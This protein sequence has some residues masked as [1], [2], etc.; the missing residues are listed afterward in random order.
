MRQAAGD[1]ETMA[2]PDSQ[3]KTGVSD[4]L[5]ALLGYSQGVVAQ[6]VDVYGRVPRGGRGGAGVSEY[7]RQ[8]LKAA[9]LAK[10][11]STFKLL[12]DWDDDGETGVDAG[13][14]ASSS[15]SVRKRFRRKG[16]SE[17]DEAAIAHDSGRNVRRRRS[18]E[19]EKD[20][21]GCG[22]SGEEEEMDR[23][24]IEKAQLERNIRERD[25][26]N[27]RRPMDRKATKRE[28]DELARRSEAMAKDDASELRRLSRHVY[29]Q[30]RKEKKV[31]EMHD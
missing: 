3:L 12:D 10:K 30:K 11:H 15:N 23:D 8:M 19:E 20:G 18:P 27:T 28:Q 2:A 24:Q 22:D 4:R 26:A 31:E 14:L 16:A 5:M 7:Q 6:F 21:D 29:L 1:G 13:F 17:D 9:A 25:A